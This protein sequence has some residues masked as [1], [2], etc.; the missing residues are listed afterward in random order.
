MEMAG[1]TYETKS[2]W[3]FFN[4]WW[5][6]TFHPLR[7]RNPLYISCC[8]SLVFLLLLLSSVFSQA[9]PDFHLFSAPPSSHHIPLQVYRPPTLFPHPS[10]ANDSVH[11]GAPQPSLSVD[12]RSWTI[13]CCCSSCWSGSSPSII[14][15]QYDFNCRPG[16]G[17]CGFEPSA[18]SSRHC[19]R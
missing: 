15:S 5:S 12:R 13:R 17:H 9:G 1:N 8:A 10:P 4:K 2:Q 3:T 7:S 19:T 6:S 14:T 11:D 16:Q 18:H